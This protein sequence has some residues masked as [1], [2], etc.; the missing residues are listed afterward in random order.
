[1]RNSAITTASTRPIETRN[2]CIQRLY[3]R[4]AAGTASTL[5]F[6]GGLGNVYGKKT[7]VTDTARIEL[8]VPRDR[9]S[10]FDPHLIA[11]YQRR[12]PGFDEKIISMYA[13][14]MS[15][16]EIVGHLRDLYGVDVSPDLIS[17]ATDAV[18][19]E[20]AAWQGR[21]LEPVYPLVFFDALRV[22]IR[23]EGLV[24]NKAVYVALGVRADGTK[25]ILGLWLEQN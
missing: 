8:D 25:E 23:D 5:A 2:D 16:R 10:T 6:S 4:A 24:R 21:L 14:G 9:Q 15:V 13:R 3:T 11:K 1:M 18:L 12:F 17:A 7:V 22:K 19:D 20:V